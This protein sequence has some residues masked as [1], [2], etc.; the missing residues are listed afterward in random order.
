[1]FAAQRFDDG[2]VASRDKGKNGAIITVY[3]PQPETMKGDKV[4]GR[5]AFSVQQGDT[6]ELVFGVFWYTATMI[7][8][9]DDRTVTLESLV[10]KDVKLPGIDDAEKISK[11]KKLLETEIPSWQLS[12]SMDELI[13]TIEQEQ[14]YVSEDLKN[15]P[16]AIAYVSTPTTLVMIDGEPRLQADK[17][18]K[19]KRVVNSAFL[20]VE[21][22]DDKKYYLYGGQFWYVSSSLTSGYQN[23]TKLPKSIAALDKQLKK[24]QTEKSTPSQEG[25]PAIHVATTPTELI[26]SKGTAE[27]ANI[28]STN[29]LYVSNSN[30]NIFKSIADQQ[31]YVLLSGRWY[32]AAKLEGPW[33][34][35]KAENL[36]AD[37]AKIP[38]GSAKDNVLS[39]VP[40]TP[41]AEDAIR[42]AQVPQTAKVDRKKATCTVTYDGEPKFEK[43][44]GTSLELAMNTSSTVLKSGKDYYCV[45]KGVWFVSGKATGPWQVS[46]ERPKDVEKIPASSSAYN[47]KYVYIYESTPEVVY[48]GYTP[49]YM[50]CYVYGP[51]VVYGTGFYYTP[52]YGPYYYPRPATFGFSMHYN[53]WCGWS[54][55]FHYSAGWFSFSMYGGGFWGP[56]VYRPPYYPPY[57]GG[58]YGRPVQINHYGDINIDRSNNIYNNRNDVSTRDVQRGQGERGQGNRGQGNRNPSVSTNDRQ[59]GQNRQNQVSQQPANRQRGDVYSDKNGNVYQRNDNG[60]WS[61]RDGNQWKQT[62]QSQQMNRDYQNRQR[63]SQQNSGFN[64]TNR[65]GN[66]GGSYRGGGGGARMGGGRRR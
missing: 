42:D 53:P 23:I 66:M 37:F 20:I 57:R 30:D 21:N 22:P 49:G 52:W 39:S 5:S 61:Q 48:V 6:S 58:M 26:Q 31:F 11:L 44:E 17:D 46:D 3:Q 35:V 45:D 41:A 12:G 33:T 64:Q 59:P 4:D 36:P 38:E 25:P 60:N 40:G 27:F 13:A 14:S 50:G 18:M 43:I 34:Y 29:L 54:M 10:V 9:R 2:R 56:P 19:M 1:L 55:G 51:T 28:T 16:P 7:T 63:S 32:K 15:D 62:Q 47:T 8:N 24:E 65:G